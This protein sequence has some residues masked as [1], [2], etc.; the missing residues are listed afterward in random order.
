MT[1]EEIVTRYVVQR[2][3]RL[4]WF[5]VAVLLGVGVAAIAKFGLDSAYP[6]WRL[7]IL[8]WGLLYIPWFIS[9]AYRKDHVFFVDAHRARC[10][11]IDRRRE[12]R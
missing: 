5:A 6:A 2:R 8:V 4:A 11:L 12:G 10:A 1:P 9:D 7:A 3:R